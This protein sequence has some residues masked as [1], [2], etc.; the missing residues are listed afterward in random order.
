MSEPHDDL[1]KLV[2][3]GDSGVG[4]SSLLV[5]FSDNTFT[6]SYMSTIGVDFKIKTIRVENKVIK[7][8]IWDTAGQE[9]FRTITSSYYRGTHG[10]ILIFDV[11]DK[12]SYTNIQ[13]WVNEI[14]RQSIDNIVKM[15]IGNKCDLES[16]R[17]VDQAQAK[18]YSDSLGMTYIECSA[19][20]AFNVEEA[21]NIIATQ[22]LAIK[23]KPVAS[24]G[25]VIELSDNKGKKEGCSC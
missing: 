12:M 8:Q 23:E 1:F 24:K 19:R 17:V 21:F 11:T 2:L 6:E 15:L 16:K 10:V 25:E 18:Q 4:K 3:L 7:L 5:R 14:D 13:K 9:K 22:I 20:S